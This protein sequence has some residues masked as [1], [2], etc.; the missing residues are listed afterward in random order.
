MCVT[1]A[2]WRYAQIDGSDTSAFALTD[3]YRVRVS[4][5][6]GVDEC[7]LVMRCCA[8]IMLCECV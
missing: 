6:T 5:L 2:L 7:M 1:V 3:D 4:G 8:R